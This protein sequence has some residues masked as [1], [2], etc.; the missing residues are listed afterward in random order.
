MTKTK[1]LFYT[2]V[3]GLIPAL[4]RVLISLTATVSVPIVTAPDLTAFGLVLAITNIN[5]LENETTL[6]P[7][8]KTK[9][10]GISLV[11]IVL[12]ACLFVASIL[13]DTAIEVFK[14][15]AVLYTSA[16]AAIAATV[17]S[18]AVWERIIAIQT[19]K[20]PKAAS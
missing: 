18:Y 5:G 19:A 17:H 20:T 15:K 4:A 11:T 9:S 13:S 6:E 8:W 3:L 2:I 7:D 14:K 10:M 1:W 12:L 16:A